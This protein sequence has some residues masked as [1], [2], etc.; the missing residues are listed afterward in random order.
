MTFS[1]LTQISSGEKLTSF[2]NKA[3]GYSYILTDNCQSIKI[4]LQTFY[5]FVCVGALPRS[6][7]VLL[8]SSCCHYVFSLPP[9]I[10][11]KYFLE[12]KNQD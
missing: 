10:L 9:S 1:L 11:P 5:S 12:I 7:P 8:T 3:C 6:L 4:K 2:C